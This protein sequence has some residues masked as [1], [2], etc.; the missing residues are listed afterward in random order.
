VNGRAVTRS[1]PSVAA[2]ATLLQGSFD[3][4]EADGTLEGWCWSPAEPLRHRTVAVSMDGREI[5]RVRCDGERD[6][7]RTAKIGSGDHAFVVCLDAADMVPGASVALALRDVETGEPIGDAQH[8]TWPLAAPS[9]AT[10]A[11][12]QGTLDRVTRDGWVSGWTWDPT[13]PEHRIELEILVDGEVVGETV[14]AGFRADLQAAGIGD[15]AHGFSF[16]LPYDVLASRGTLRIAVRERDGAAGPG[17]LLDAPVELRIGRL[18]TAEQRVLDVERQVRLLRGQLDALTR[19]AVERPHADQRAAQLL[20]GTVAGF[21]RELADG[22]APAQRGYGVGPFGGGGLRGA[23]DD[24]AARLSPLT[25]RLAERPVATV[26]VPA[27]ASA[28]AVHRCLVALHEAGI[29]AIADIVLLEPPDSDPRVAL[30]PS[31]V[32]NLGFV[33][34]APGVGLVAGCDDV[35]HSGRGAYAAFLSPDCLPTRSWLTELVDTFG[36][37][38]MAAVVGGVVARADGLLQHAGFEIAQGGMLRDPGQFAEADQPAFRYLR[39]VD[40]VAG[41]GFAVERRRYLAAGGMSR[42]Y[43]TLTGGLVDLCVRLRA[44]GELTFV[45]P[46]AIATWADTADTDPART[47]PDLSAPNEESRRLRLTLLAIPERAS[48]FV[49]HALVI[50]DEVPRPDRDAGSIMTLEQLRLLRSLGWRVTFAPASGA[51]VPAPTRRR[52]EREGIEVAVPP[53][54]TS[55]TH[56]L[57]EQGADL[58]LVHIYRHA[59]ATVLGERVREF[60]PRA[61]LVFAPADLHFVREEREAALTG[62]DPALV[63]ATRT[64]ELAGVRGADATLVHSDHELDLLA[65]E[66]SIDA[67]RLLLLR[68]IVRPIAAPPPFAGRDGIAFA[69]NF[70]HPPNLDAMVWFCAEV[71]PELRRLRPGIVLHIVGADPPPAIRALARD[72]IRV[73][74]WI[75]DLPGLLGQMR[76]TVAPLRYGAGFK[77]KVATSLAYGVPAVITP[78]AA[79]GMGLADGDGVVIAADPAAFALA[80]ATVHD[81]AAVW[82]ALSGRALDRVAMLYSPAAARATYAGL[83]TRLNLPAR[84]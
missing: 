62:R 41:L 54:W 37:E 52:L 55:V 49:G 14:A 73:R 29:D 20:F 19:E 3:R 63:E 7:L 11:A 84:V 48:D 27:I 34:L 56:Y 67:E 72:D 69:A 36:S 58:D 4:A 15:G 35:A 5:V 30:L 46:T 53:H 26:C 21:F 6:D 31:I 43:A 83:L 79:E 81:D 51:A 75:A 44:G 1:R 25:L 28:E 50:D 60:A 9:P 61:K 18:A 17:R 38:P 42:H 39:A 22:V 57:R 24:L 2:P 68:W 59:N 8:V 13:T 10:R 12:L 80:V 64:Q 66:P 16:A 78:S 40:A 76:L 65:A 77:G 74:G 82:A 45:Q 32:R 23:I 70:G 47:L 33:H 71:M